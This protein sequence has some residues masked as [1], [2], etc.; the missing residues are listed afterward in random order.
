MEKVSKYEK[1]NT[2]HN[3]CWRSGPEYLL[4]PVLV[5]CHLQHLSICYNINLYLNILHRG[6]YTFIHSEI[7]LEFIKTISSSHRFV[8]GTVLYIYIYIIVAVYI[9]SFFDLFYFY[10]FVNIY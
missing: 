9:P 3:G 5:V 7:H 6:M 8:C 10:N 1:N 2:I 4:V